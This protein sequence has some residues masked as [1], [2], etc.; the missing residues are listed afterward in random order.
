MDEWK[1]LIKMKVFFLFCYKYIIVYNFMLN[2]KKKVRLMIFD[3]CIFF[4]KIVSD[5]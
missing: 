3:F 2:V 4:V 1:Y 5:G